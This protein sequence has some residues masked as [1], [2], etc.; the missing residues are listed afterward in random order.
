MKT[1]RGIR[2]ALPAPS[3][4]PRRSHARIAQA[5]GRTG[6]AMATASQLADLRARLA[7]AEEALRAIRGGEVDAVVV[8]SQHGPQVFTLEGAG[9]AYRML[10]ESMNEG[11][12]TLTTDKTIL[13]A[14]QCFARMVKCPLERVL[15]GSFRRFISKEDRATLRPLLKR[16]GK[17]D[18]KV[19]L[20]LR[21][22]D[23]SQ[24]PVQVSF[25]PLPKN[26]PDP[27]VIGMVLTDLTEVER[28]AGSLRAL[29][30]RVV[31]ALETERG[32]VAL[33]LHDRIT[34]HLC[35]VLFRC[36]A[37]EGKLPPHDRQAQAEARK[38]R[39]MVGK[40]AEEVERIS[41]D[42]RPG[43]LDQLGLTAV[44][45]TTSTEFAHRTGIT[46]K[47]VCPPQMARL[48]A[49]IE[50][51]LYRILQESLRNVARHASARHVTVRLRQGNA[52]VQMVISDDG[53][54]FDPHRHATGRKGSNGLGLLSISERASY[55]DGAFKIR[56]VPGA[57]TGIAVTVPLPVGRKAVAPTKRR[58]GS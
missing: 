42:L 54:G 24:T 14:N 36:E 27:K 43:V 50:L 58:A 38:L 56:S 52:F 32:R 29:T 34:Q 31:E 51:A 21:A 9:D 53:I 15:G 46:V 20:V 41:R 13:Y 26:G 44:L 12:L 10:I 25:R 55:V 35:A 5:S 33:E 30:H 47:L 1:A 23:G 11:A 17:P 3:R 48:P 39:D 22:T 28:T 2:T 7:N 45:R 16:A 4:L 57:G 18:A 8:A 19:R 49:D 6:V 37:L 40:T